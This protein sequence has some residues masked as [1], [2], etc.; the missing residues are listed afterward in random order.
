VDFEEL[1]ALRRHSPA[2]RL[3]RADHAPLLLSF[4][5]GVFQDENVRSISASALAARLDETLYDLNDRL[6]EG[7]YPRAAKTYLDEWAAPANGWLRKYYPIGSQEAHFDATSDVEKALSWIAGLR[8]RSFVGTES[9]LNTVFELLRQMVYG[10]E[11]DPESRIAEL[12]RQRREIDA[13]ISRVQSGDL[14]IMEPVALRDRYQQLTA[15]ARGLLSDFREV[16]GNF[17]HL[18]RQLRE[19][20]AGWDG[21]KAQLL[22]DVV[23]NRSS[24]SESDQGRSFHAFYDFLLSQDRQDQLVDLLQRVQG[25]DEIGEPDPRLRHIHHDWL[26][27]GERTQ[28]TVRMLSEQLRRFLDDQVWLEN[29]RVVEVL[30]GIESSA[31]RL[32]NQGPIELS[33]EMDA[34][35]PRVVL[36]MERPLYRPSARARIDSTGVAGGV[37]ELDTSLLFEQVYVDTEVLA[38]TVR[39]VLQARDQVGLAE[40]LQSRPVEQ[41]LAEIVGYLG[42]EDSA[43]DVT[44]NEAVRQRITWTDAEGARRSATLPAV[45]YSRRRMMSA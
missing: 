39:Q 45:T 27:A 34:T 6:G 17:R 35:A 13:E 40:V 29:R 36:A 19:Q 15:T 32:R 30:R 37:D 9:R 1:Q 24:I 22:D 43:F 8:P 3:L 20:I 14:R 11:T 18:D 4:L 31:L 25:L 44:F 21:T 38:T 33:I 41:G 26:Q 28:A 2:W 7:T 42:L 10:A 12:E 23:G 5:G 16:E